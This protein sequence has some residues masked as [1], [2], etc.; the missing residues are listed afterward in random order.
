[1][2]SE[3]ML[4][5]NFEEM[6]EAGLP[7]KRG[8]R[9]FHVEDK[10]DN[11]AMASGMWTHRWAK[12]AAIN[13]P[14][15]SKGLGVR[16]FE[17]AAKDLPCFCVGIGPS[18]DGNI[19][20]LKIAQNRSLI[21]STDAAIKPLLANGIIPHVALTFDCGENQKT[22]LEDI[23]VDIQSEIF[24]FVNTCT[25]PETINAWKG[26]KIY[27]NQYHQ[28]DEFIA[29]LLPYIYQGIGQLPSVGTVGNMLIVLAHFLGMKAIHL[30]GMDLC[31]GAGEK[32]GK[33]GWQYRAADYT[34]SDGSW[35][36]KDNP[37][38]Y[39]NDSRVLRSFEE[40]VNGT[41]Y[42]VDPELKMYREALVEV[43]GALRIVPI[44]CSTGVLNQ[45]FPHKTIAESIMLHCRSEVPKYRTVLRNAKEFFGGHK[46]TFDQPITGT[47]P[48][49]FS[50][51]KNLQEA[52]TYGHGA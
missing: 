1:M 42:R 27:Y 36:K 16:E 6:K 21:L 22:L 18:L 44:D 43:L 47:W 7:V 25:N 52:V 38:L 11:R 33:A 10:T 31:Y 51:T 14:I 4:N 15:V 34:F 2:P 39:E 9:Q 41:K 28:Q 23:P 13:Y 46:I 40:D 45:F 37:I 29:K 8:V 50:V 49:Q 30:V 12:N 26:P 5:L 48:S 24:L 20:E 32:Q 17:D 19:R 3:E 35:V